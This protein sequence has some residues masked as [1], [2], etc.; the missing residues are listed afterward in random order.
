MTKFYCIL[1]DCI[2]KLPIIDDIKE[3]YD[4]KLFQHLS[5]GS[6][7]YT[8]FNILT[9]CVPSDIIKNGVG[10]L[11]FGDGDALQKH[12]HKTAKEE[13]YKRDGYF[14][15]WK[16]L[17][18][19]KNVSLFHILDKNNCDVIIHNSGFLGRWVKPKLGGL[20]YNNEYDNFKNIH[21]SYSQPDGVSD[22]FIKEFGG[23]RFLSNTNYLINE[24]YKLE[25]EYIKNIQ[26]PTNKNMFFVEDDHCFH[27]G[28]PN[29][30]LCIEKYLNCWNF[31]EPNAV[32]FIFTD[33]GNTRSRLFPQEVNQVWGMI[34]DNRI[35]APKINTPIMSSYDLYN[36]IL[37]VFNINYINPYPVL[38]RSLYKTFDPNRIYFIEDSRLEVCNFE[39]DTLNCFKIIEWD[40]FKPKCM[41]QFTYIKGLTPS[42]KIDND[43]KNIYNVFI[44][45]N[46]NLNNYKWN[47]EIKYSCNLSNLS[48]SIIDCNIKELFYALKNKYRNIYN[49]PDLTNL[50]SYDLNKRIIKNNNNDSWL[51]TSEHR[52]YLGKITLH[53]TTNILNVSD[54]IIDSFNKLQECENLNK[55]QG[56]T[57][58]K[59]NISYNICN[60]D[61]TSL[62]NIY[63]NFK[64]PLFHVIGDSHTAIFTGTNSIQKKWPYTEKGEEIEKDD[65]HTIPFFKTYRINAGTAY[66]SQIKAIPIIND[67][68]DKGY[69]KN[70][71]YIIFSYGEVDCRAHLI[72]QFKLQNRNEN[73]IIKDCVDRLIQT[74]LYYKNKNIKIIAYGPGPTFKD[75][76]KHTV[77]INRWFGNEN[78]RNKV[79]DYFNSYYKKKCNE[80]NIPFFTLFYDLIDEHYNTLDG[81]HL[82]DS[83]HLSIKVIPLI[84][85]YIKLL[86][87]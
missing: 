15:D 21:F 66:N 45:T 57:D 49:I 4:F 32:F 78:Q 14:E 64:Y 39:T 70:N 37:D 53:N 23:F 56:S 80:N 28:A 85:K 7:M 72:K 67:I 62:F 82:N 2:P 81:Y 87:I 84:I 79:T 19:N 60:E 8:F 30:D 35:N 6:T 42:S 36:T 22:D 13:Y 20:K 77:P 11:S 25:K 63:S 34:K 16:W 3:K 52:R 76:N 68:I 74:L 50:K 86:D 46:F 61:A 54:N 75:K 31:N 29:A 41:I 58:F 69:I 24:H 40:N 73:E 48:D 59:Y 33:H 18:E 27:D 17:E 1:I 26:K 12:A 51:I 9:G 47:N 43:I 5:G 38:S 83:M 65:F 55:Y 44:K 71:D 10:Y